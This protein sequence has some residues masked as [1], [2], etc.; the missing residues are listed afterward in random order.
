MTSPGV[1]KSF[2]VLMLWNIF[3]GFVGALHIYQFVVAVMLSSNWDQKHSLWTVSPLTNGVWCQAPYSTVACLFAFSVIFVLHQNIQAFRMYRD[4]NLW[5]VCLY[6]IQMTLDSL[7]LWELLWRL[8]TIC[9][10]HF[11][12]LSS[13]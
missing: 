13:S 8:L 7:C 4:Y 10:H 2:V 11:S 9:R 12:R 3:M 6:L 1:K 5:C